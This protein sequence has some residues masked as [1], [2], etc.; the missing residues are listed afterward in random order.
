M[1]IEYVVSL[2]TSMMQNH[3]L[4]FN[5]IGD[6]PSTQQSEESPKTHAKVVPTPKA[7][8]STK[9]PHPEGQN[10]SKIASLRGSDTAE[11][12]GGAVAKENSTKSVT[13]AFLSHKSDHSGDFSIHGVSLTRI[14]AGSILVIISVVSVYI[15]FSSADGDSVSEQS[16][17]A[18]TREELLAMESCDG[19][20]ALTYQNADEQSKQ[21]LELLFRCHI[22]PGEEFAHSKLAEDH[23]GECVWIANHML[24]ERP[25]EEWLTMCQEA[26]KTFNQSVTACYAARQN[27]RSRYYNQDSPSAMR[28]DNSQADDSPQQGDGDPLP[29]SSGSGGGSR[30]RKD[31]SSGIPP[32][33]KTPA[34][35]KSL[36]ERCRQIMAASDARK[37]KSPG[38]TSAATSSQDQG[39]TSEP[40]KPGSPGA[41]QP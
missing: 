40:A 38:L 20:W 41:K 8:N 30:S 21:G 37:P 28:Y 31:G 6:D 1:L 25:L 3:A 14:L 35:K 7:H 4:S 19:T 36:M 5:D 26:Q 27:V 16:T 10:M 39:G 17:T 12:Q 33:L 23:V 15:I 32:I 18:K 11:G 29:G 22:I 24:K 34:D 13:Y 2:G 9:L